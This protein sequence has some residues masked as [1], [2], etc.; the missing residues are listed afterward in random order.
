[1]HQNSH[2]KVLFRIIPVELH[3]NG[4]SV[5][6][7]AFLDGGSDSTLVEKSLLE[8]LGVQGPVSPLCMQWTNG[9]K[10]LEEDSR[11]VYIKISGVG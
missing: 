4:R 6:T 9:I 5:Q 3:A 8:Q 1:M 7:Y 10:R 11:K 2:S